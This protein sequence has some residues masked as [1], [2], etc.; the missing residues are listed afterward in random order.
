MANSIKF[1]GFKWTRGDESNP[2]L[3]LV[4][5]ET[6]KALHVTVPSD[7]STDWNVAADSN[8][9]VYI[10]SDTTPATD[11]IL[12]G[13]HTGTVADID[14]VGGTTLQLKIDGTSAATLTATA[15]TLADAVNIVVNTT[16][17]T[18]IGTATTQKLG[19]FNAAP[20]AQ[21]SAYTQTYSTADKT[22]ANPTATSIAAA[23]PANPPNVDEDG[24]AAG[25]FITRATRVAF[26][27][28]VTNLIT[29]NTELDL[30]YEALLVDVADLKQLVNSVVDDLQAL[31]LVG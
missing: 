29:H 27:T 23:V 21:P 10:H 28:T 3:A 1:K 19:F 8:P 17:G 24:I 12:I 16:T 18:K 30:D 11:Y 31:G 25:G 13:R 26:V 20:A 4:V 6:S 9:A 15:L 22:H 7:A 2:A 14:I 5:D